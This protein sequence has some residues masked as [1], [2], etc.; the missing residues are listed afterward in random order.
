MYICLCVIINMVENSFSA[1]IPVEE[2]AKVDILLITKLRL[3]YPKRSLIAIFSPWWSEEEILGELNS[4]TEIIFA[5][6]FVTC[7]HAG[8]LV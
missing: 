8:A 1:S 6:S 2:L 7:G 4:L 3:A 5:A